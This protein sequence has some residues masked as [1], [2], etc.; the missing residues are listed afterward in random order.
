MWFNKKENKKD[1]SLPELP[2]LP[3]L[4]DLPQKIDFSAIRPRIED[5]PILKDDLPPLPSPSSKTDEE[6]KSEIAQEK[7]RLYTKEISPV[8]K[9]VRH[10]MFMQPPRP[11]VVQPPAG[12]RPQFQPRAMKVD[13]NE[14][15]QPVFVR[16]DKFQT[17]VKNFSEIKSQLSQIESYLEEIKEIRAKEDHELG[18]WEHE[19]LGIKERLESIDRGIFSKL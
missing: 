16:L 2:N 8:Q 3:E 14:G 11:G 15:N 17:A 19:I 5:K 12:P 10:E 13:E 4:P 6:I 18:E 9:E 1:I 7:A